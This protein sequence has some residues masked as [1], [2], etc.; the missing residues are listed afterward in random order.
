VST[1]TIGLSQPCDVV[2]ANKGTLFISETGK[3]RVI[4][5][6]KDGTVSSVADGLAKP[7]G[8]AVWGDTLLVLDH[9]TKELYA[10]E[11]STQQRQTLTSHLPVGDP[12]GLTRGPMDFSNSLA[13]GPDGTIYIPGDGEGSV[14]TLK[15]L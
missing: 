7:R 9:G 6:D 14:L 8:M 5:V 13:V 2:G 12:A 11:L 10:I 3:G 1:V 15:R 4:K